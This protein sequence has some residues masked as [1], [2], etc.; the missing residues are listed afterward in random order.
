ME[1]KDEVE[2]KKLWDRPFSFFIPNTWCVSTA[3]QR[4]LNFLLIV[5]ISEQLAQKFKAASC[6][7]QESNPRHLVKGGIFTAPPHPL[8]LRKS[9]L[10]D[11][12]QAL[13]ELEKKKFSFSMYWEVSPPK[14]GSA[15]QRPL[16]Q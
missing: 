6:P 12:C 2:K 11:S 5:D 1:I 10:Q 14:K 16:D 8:S 9:F 4:R 3:R 15:A 7:K 13:R